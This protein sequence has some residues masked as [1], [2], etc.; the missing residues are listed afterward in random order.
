MRECW[1]SPY[2]EVIYTSGMWEHAETAA[3]ILFER[4]NDGSW[5]D[6]QDVWCYTVMNW[7]SKSPTDLLQE[8]GW[9]RHST[10]SNKWIV[11]EEYGIHP[12]QDQ[13][14]K[15]FDLTGEIVE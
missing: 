2:G 9:I 7:S 4:Y 13:K 11:G 15:I 1:L 10:V 8:K 5:E 12:T 6:T 14:D 3:K